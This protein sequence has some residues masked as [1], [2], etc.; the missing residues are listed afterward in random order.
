MRIEIEK[1]DTLGLTLRDWV[2]GPERLDDSLHVL[3]VVRVHHAVKITRRIVRVGPAERSPLPRLFRARLH[4]NL[5][6][7]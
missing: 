2:K 4:H 7:F 3:H 5:N 6:V 1:R